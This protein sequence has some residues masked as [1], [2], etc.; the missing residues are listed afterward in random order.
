M[1]Q[2]PTKDTDIF[3]SRVDS[4]QKSNS[5]YVESVTVKIIS[6]NFQILN[7]RYLYFGVLKIGKHISLQNALVCLF[8]EDWDEEFI[9]FDNVLLDM[10]VSKVQVLCFAKVQDRKT[11]EKVKLKKPFEIHCDN[12]TLCFTR[13]IDEELLRN[14]T[15][16]NFLKHNRKR[17]PGFYN[18]VLSKLRVSCMLELDFDDQDVQEDDELSD[19]D[20]DHAIFPY[21]L[22]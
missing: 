9:L 21:L 15:L 7:G 16:R 10:D 22:D 11:K 1:L 2:S 20:F 5:H 6:S 13:A 14:E 3:L 18:V 8:R 17:S 19:C 12:A 4:V